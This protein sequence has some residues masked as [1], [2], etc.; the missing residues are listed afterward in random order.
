MA[1]IFAMF[2]FAWPVVTV[3]VLATVFAVYAFVDGVFA[4]MAGIQARWLMLS[5]LGVIGILAGILA[6]FYPG[7]TAVSIV[8]VIGF[9]AIIRGATEIAAAIQ[10][11]K[12]IANEWALILGGA[13]S[14]L[15]GV[16]LLAR[17]G[18]GLISVIFIV[19]IYALLWGILLVL[20]A[21]RVKSH[22]WRV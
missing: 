19:G 16:L 14:V 21:F 10:L 15:F 17:P 1:I 3:L 9:W 11:R 4:L 2:A 7:A 18:V 6:F 13:L 20:A 22:P 5:L 12:V 8:L